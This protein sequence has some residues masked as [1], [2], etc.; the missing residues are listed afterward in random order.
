[1]QLPDLSITPTHLFNLLN[2]ATKSWV[3]TIAAEYKIFDLTVEKKTAAEIATSLQTHEG[4]TELFLNA[5]CALDLLKKK[6]NT[7]CNTQL[8]DTFLVKDRE[9]YLGAFLT[10]ADQWNFPT[11][12][13][14]KDAIKNGPAPKTED[15][16]DMGEMF[17]PN[18]KSMRNL[19]RAGSSQLIAKEISKLPEFPAMKKMLELGGAHGMD[20]IAIALKNTSLKGFF[21]DVPAVV[22]VT[23][24]VI[25]EYDM[26]KR[27][28]VMEGDYATDP[29]G[30]GYDL[31]YAKATINFYKDNL[32]ALFTKIYEALNPGGVF[33]S[34]HD[35]LTDESTKPGDMV[36]SWLF[37]GLTS[38]DFSL[39]R[40]IVPDTMLQAG[41]KSV[42]IKPLPFFMSGSMD[43]CIGKK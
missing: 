7:Y 40:D 23:K 3:L 31:I 28:T 36:I 37:S 5:L 19:S 2:G 8:A 29:I 9:C 18:V 4:N 42:K 34:V 16:G 13:D 22:K 39:D 25:A 20:S 11:K 33:V 12:A 14:M 30:D 24:E 26:E 6:N 27:I 41:F 43:M 10:L 32:L 1:M 21:L 35:G 38:C 17:A 15:F